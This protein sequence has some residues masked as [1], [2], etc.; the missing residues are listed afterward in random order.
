MEIP[1]FSEISSN[2]IPMRK[3]R[4]IYKGRVIRLITKTVRLPNANFIELELIR[5][6]GA[7]LIIPFLDTG[8]I[9]LLRQFRA[10]IGRYLYELPAGTISPGESAL[11]CAKREI[12]EETGYSARKF[13][14]LGS[15]YPVPGYSTEKITIYK[16]FELDKAAS[17][18]EADEVIKTCVL[19]KTGVRRLFRDRKIND[20]KSICALTMCGWL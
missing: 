8:K 5:H 6:P 4:V 3:E 16:A 17:A 13:M 10:V 11:S 2:I 15:I 20:A 12:V 7:A 18:P 1:R 9:I 19:D 14:R